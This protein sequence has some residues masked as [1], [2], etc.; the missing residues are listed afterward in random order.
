MRFFL[1]TALLALT[2]PA[3]TASAAPSAEETRLR[4]AVEHLVASQKSAF[5]KTGGTFA[6]SGDMMIEKAGSYYAVTLPD[7][8][9]IHP[10]RAQTA[11]GLIALNASPAG[12]GRWNITMALPTPIVT[13]GQDGAVQSEL[14]LGQQ[15]FSGRWDE[16]FRNFT[17]L[18]TL[19][20]NVILRLPQSG[21][22]QPF[23]SAT[24]A[25]MGYG[26][27]LSDTSKDKTDLAFRLGIE[28]LKAV[29][30]SP[31]HAKL[32]PSDATVNIDV[33]DLP[34][35]KLGDIQKNLLTPG[36]MA[37]SPLWLTQ[38]LSQSG[39]EAVINTIQ[40]KNAETGLNLTGRVKPSP[41]SP[42]QHTGKLTLDVSRIDQ[43][44]LGLNSAAANSP[45][46]EQGKLQALRVALTMMSALG[47]NTSGEGGAV[48][49]YDV[50][51]TPDG[52][53]MMNGTDFSAVIGGVTQATGRKAAR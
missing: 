15:F 29:G 5:E 30:L 33:K 16:K 52:K 45:P 11:L 42:L 46:S 1:M 36:E 2:L 7:I 49:R 19:Y 14:L 23:S 26:F 35:D 10:N 9:L 21:A 3:A 24:I 28:G 51:M 18:K 40:L 27:D 41:T 13:K 34:I 37:G 22:G 39:S 47:Q 38:L 44:L 20:Q 25:K 48:K 6:A 12:E 53:V 43:L 8:T 4:Q 17:S 50:E 31:A 32:F